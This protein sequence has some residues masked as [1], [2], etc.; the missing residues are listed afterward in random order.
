MVEYGFSW[1]KDQGGG[2][3]VLPQKKNY[4]SVFNLRNENEFKQFETDCANVEIRLLTARGGFSAKDKAVFLLYPTKEMF[5][6]LEEYTGA[7]SVLVL[8]WNEY[9]SKEWKEKYSPKLIPGGNKKPEE[10]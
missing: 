2:V 5:E 8:D 3:V 4:Y 1:L 9:F 10:L 7:K 6:E